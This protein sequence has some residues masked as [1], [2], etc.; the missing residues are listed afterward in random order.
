VTAKSYCAR[1]HYAFDRAYGCADCRAIERERAERESAT[2]AAPAT[3]A[4][5]DSSECDEYEFAIG[6]MYGAVYP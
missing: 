5:Q 6:A 2:V 3:T 1:H 4:L